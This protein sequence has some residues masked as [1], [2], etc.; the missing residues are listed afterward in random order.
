MKPLTHK[1]KEQNIIKSGK[2]PICDT[3]K[4][5]TFGSRL[6]ELIGDKSGRS[7][8]REIGISYSTLH[9]YITDVSSPTL[10]NLIAL[11]RHTNVNLEW[12]ATGQESKNKETSDIIE[13]VNLLQSDINSEIADYREVRVSAGFGGF[14]DEIYNNAPKTIIENDWLR[15][16]GF[17]A[18]DCA[19]FRVSGESME[20]ALRNGED[21]IVHLKEHELKEGEIF[22]L[23]H[24]GTM[25]VKKVQ[26]TFDGVELLSENTD[27]KP[28][29]LEQAEAD[30]LMVIGRVVR[31]YRDF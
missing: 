4:G 10:D 21:I 6:K 13:K 27:Y 5:T 25:W 18:K 20:P 17:K 28:I 29:K 2:D 12:L 9:N 8:A 1:E 7:F 16:R 11:A 30:T 26:I 24:K 19:M 15:K 31:V 22:V 3:I 23:N 14:N